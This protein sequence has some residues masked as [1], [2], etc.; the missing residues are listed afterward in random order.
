MQPTKKILIENKKMMF[1]LMVILVITIAVLLIIRY[2][3][4]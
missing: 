1:G 3:I 2:A 4:L